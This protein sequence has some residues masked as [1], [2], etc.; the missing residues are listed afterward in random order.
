MTSP[1]VR[2]SSARAPHT[3]EAA[4]LVVSAAVAPLNA[5]PR[6]GSGQVTQALAGH[7]LLLLQRQDEWLRVRGRDAYE[8][9]IHQGYTTTASELGIPK[10]AVWPGN[11]RLSLGCTVR[12]QAGHARRLPLGAYVAP[13]EH[14]EDGEAITASERR[15][16]FPEDA[17]AVARTAIERFAG[18]PYQWGGITPWG[19]DCSG[20]VRSVFALHSV[21][22][23]RDAWQQ[24]ERGSEAP[25]DTLSLLP[26]DLLFFSDRADNRITHVAIAI[27]DGRMVHLALGR[28][29]YAVEQLDGTAD[30]YSA[31]L[32]SRF[33]FARR[34]IAPSRT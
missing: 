5:E 4:Q 13:N 16:R 11:A 2:Q 34:V 10:G 6:V 17:D 7:P 3:L 21:S 31:I 28:G 24:A 22:L 19:A 14:L 12:T 9:W 18:T 25:A 29:G 27:G 30:E 15:A 23:P 26:S 8:G 33:R 1:D 20:L 32:M